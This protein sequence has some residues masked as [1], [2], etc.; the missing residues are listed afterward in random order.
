MNG[1]EKKKHNKGEIQLA[2]WREKAGSDNK[3]TTPRI[4]CAYKRENCEGN[5]APLIIRSSIDRNTTSNPI[6]I[7]SRH[8]IYAL[9]DKAQH[10][11]TKFMKYFGSLFRTYRVVGS[12]WWTQTMNPISL[13]LSFP[14]RWHRDNCGFASFKS[15]RNAL[16]RKLCANMFVS[17][18]LSISPHFCVVFFFH[19]FF[20]SLLVRT[21]S[22]WDSPY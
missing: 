1:I 13:S 2:K 14:F 5:N 4:N 22:K 19:S 21:T 10:K 15:H 17:R 6:K 8:T 9:A 7:E 18:L 3:Y 11:N 20:L 16:E 12:I